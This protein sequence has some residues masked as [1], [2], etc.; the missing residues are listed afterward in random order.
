M[1]SGKRGRATVGIKIKPGESGWRLPS[2]IG[3]RGR[4]MRFFFFFEFQP[5]TKEDVEMGG[6]R[7]G[8]GW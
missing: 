8:D 1:E 6:G 3:G 5:A 7:K 4:G 2:M